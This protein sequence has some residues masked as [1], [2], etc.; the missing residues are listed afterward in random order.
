M[1]REDAPCPLRR[2]FAVIPGLNPQ[3][4]R[5]RLWTQGFFLDF[6]LRGIDGLDLGES[7]ATSGFFVVLKNTWFTPFILS[8]AGI[9]L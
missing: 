2:G 3:Q 5:G 7:L 9:T 4:R 1:G 8:K 6:R